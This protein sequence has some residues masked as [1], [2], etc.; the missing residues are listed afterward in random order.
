M[1]FETNSTKK[2]R[3][4]YYARIAFNLQVMVMSGSYEYIGADSL[5]YIVDWV[6][7]ENGFRA[8]APHLPKVVLPC[9]SEKMLFF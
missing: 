5:T 2:F 4:A 1:E 6:A 3:L 9:I 8:S 7:D